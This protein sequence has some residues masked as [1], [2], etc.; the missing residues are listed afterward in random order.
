MKPNTG[1]RTFSF[2]FFSFCYSLMGKDNVRTRPFIYIQ[3][4]FKGQGS[5][6]GYNRGQLEEVLARHREV[7]S[8]K[9]ASL[10]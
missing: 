1:K 9:Q 8:E 10:T 6:T 5:C 3:R 4:K 7:L 2:I